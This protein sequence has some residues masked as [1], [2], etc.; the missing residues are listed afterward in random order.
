MFPLKMGLCRGF[1]TGFAENN[2]M[3]TAI[4]TCV[5]KMVLA[6]DSLGMTCEVKR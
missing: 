1:R 2:I 4:R 6:L 3:L 5:A